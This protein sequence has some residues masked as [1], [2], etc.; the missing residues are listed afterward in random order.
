[1]SAEGTPGVTTENPHPQKVQR[2]DFYGR[3]RYCCMFGKSSKSIL[4]YF[5]ANAK[6]LVDKKPS[7]PTFVVAVLKLLKNEDDQTK[8]M[9]ITEAIY[10]NKRLASEV[11]GPDQTPALHSAIRARKKEIV[12]ALL[13][14]DADASLVD[15]KGRGPLHCAAETGELDIVKALIEGKDGPSSSALVSAQDSYGITPIGEACRHGHPGVAEYLLRK[16]PDAGQ[17]AGSGGRTPLHIAADS[18]HLGVIK[19]LLDFNILVNDGG[20]GETARFA[21]SEG[22][23]TPST[24]ARAMF[25]IN[26]K[27]VAGRT[28]LNLACRRGDLSIVKL[29][30]EKHADPGILSKNGENC[31]WDAARTGHDKIVGFLLEKK[32]L[33]DKINRLNSSG[34]TLLSACCSA[35]S[36]TIVRQLLAKGADCTIANKDGSKPITEAILCCDVESLSILLESPKFSE[37]PREALSYEVGGKRSTALHLACQRHDIKLIEFLVSKMRSADCIDKLNDGQDM[38]VLH[39]ASRMGFSRAV[40]F[41]LDEYP[42]FVKAANNEGWTPLHC[43]CHEALGYR[44]VTSI[45]QMKDVNSDHGTTIEMDEWE[46]RENYADTVRILVDRGADVKA[47]NNNGNTALHLAAMQ[48]HTER[49]STILDMLADEAALLILNNNKE[50]PLVC[51]LKKRRAQ[52]AE[53]LVDEMRWITFAGDETRD[54]LLRFF[55]QRR[56]HRL[57]ASI[58]YKEARTSKHARLSSISQGDKALVLAAFIGSPRLVWWLLQSSIPGTTLNRD[59]AAA[60]LVCTEETLARQ[61]AGR[62]YSISDLGDLTTERHLTAFESVLELL[63]KPP[64][65]N[66][67]GQTLTV[68]SQYAGAQ[69][70]PPHFLNNYKV[71]ILDLYK[72]QFIQHSASVNEALYSGDPSEMMKELW[73]RIDKLDES[74]GSLWPIQSTFPDDT[75]RWMMDMSKAVFP[76][77][78]TKVSDRSWLLCSGKE[79]PYVAP[80]W[81]CDALYKSSDYKALLDFYQDKETIIHGTRTLDE[82]FYH[83]CLDSSLT[84]SLEALNDD[85]ILGKNVR[86]DVDK[87][88]C[89]FQ[90]N[91]DQL[92]IWVLDEKTVIT[93]T[94]HRLDWEINPMGGAIVDSLRDAM[95]KIGEV[96][97]DAYEMAAF[98]MTSCISS[99]DT[100]FPMTS[101]T[102]LTS[103]DES[104]PRMEDCSAL[105][106]FAYAIDQHSSRR[107]SSCSVPE[108]F[109]VNIKEAFNNATA[110][111]S[112]SEI[113]LYN[114][115][116]GKENQK[117]PTLPSSRWQASMAE[118]PEDAVAVLSREIKDMRDELKILRLIAEKQKAVQAEFRRLAFSPDRHLPARDMVQELLHMDKAAERIEASI[119]VTFALQHNAKAFEQ[120]RIT[121]QQGRIMVV[122]TLVT[123]VFLPLSFFTSLFAMQFETSRTTP[124]WVYGIIL[125]VSAVIVSAIC[126]YVFRFWDW[127]AEMKNKSKMM[128]I[129]KWLVR[130]L[131]SLAVHLYGT[132]PLNHVLFRYD[133][134]F[135][136]ISAISAWAQGA[137]DVLD[138]KSEHW[139]HNAASV[140]GSDA[141]S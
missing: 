116:V 98:I 137:E 13:R 62:R 65:F 59:I 11:G 33:A 67:R 58:L 8:E 115:F 21:D 44:N 97:M 68:R 22:E 24:D 106:E 46:Y 105:A 75:M 78:D 129:R 88:A 100:H 119:N 138:T 50:T 57:V 128:M 28:A 27:T 15:K 25:D 80:A 2:A 3:V 125:G 63:R 110:K 139:G 51:S 64:P 18:G 124:G 73:T 108:Q 93:S 123:I 53:M 127:Y 82:Y 79:M 20:T 77:D 104:L 111:L 136:A 107:D 118:A 95:G 96:P 71:E 14:N 55:I 103:R 60:K 130:A 85:Q 16:F 41:L 112:I 9:F 1:M 61:Q 99:V 94:T 131:A 109:R 5:V 32:D 120:A 48:G 140:L 38:T 89:G 30:L 102:S 47:Q 81:R 49:V 76:D 29:L 54:D 35:K 37:N 31:L 23:N 134:L 52:V 6:H 42:L 122:F 92:W 43:A 101:L 133:L 40:T 56:D 90:V 132:P 117:F 34:I 10:S 19:M 72:D 83:S 113:K 45:S 26:Q 7:D 141:K 17:R 126:S 86:N 135:R 84:E 87:D 4:K 70:Q 121:I 66:E 36:H 114:M 39:E 91:V 74:H 69:D 12:Y